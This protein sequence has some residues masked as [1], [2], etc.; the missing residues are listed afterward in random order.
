MTLASQKEYCL[1]L[2]EESERATLH[3][4]E[5]ASEMELLQA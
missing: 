5:E 3:Y 1:K 2:L 4:R